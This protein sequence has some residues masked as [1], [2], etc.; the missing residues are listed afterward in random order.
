MIVTAES[1]AAAASAALAS[2]R[3][4]TIASGRSGPTCAPIGAI[5]DSPTP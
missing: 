3:A 1:S 2:P 4:W 5:C